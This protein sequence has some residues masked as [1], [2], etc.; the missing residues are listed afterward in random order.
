MLR[1]NKGLLIYLFIIITFNILFLFYPLLNVFGFEFSLANSVLLFFV[2]GIYVINR[3]SK[4]NGISGIVKSDFIKTAIVFIIFLIIPLIITL[5]HSFFTTF[6]SI[7]DGFLFYTVITFPSVILGA[8]TGMLTFSLFNKMRIFLFIIITIL[9][10][11][12]ALFEFYFNPQV[13]F[14]NPVFGFFPGTIYDEGI[15]VTTKLVFYRL[16]NLA[17]FGSIIYFVFKTAGKHFSKLLLGFDSML[18]ASVFIYFSPLLGFSTTNRSLQQDLGKDYKT[19]HFDI[20]FS[21]DI[22]DTLAKKI[23]LEHEYDYVSLA[24]FF[25]ETPQG[26]ITSYVFSSNEQKGKLFGSKNADVAKPWLQQIYISSDSYDQ[27][28]KHELAHVFTREFGTGIFKVADGLNPALIEGAAVAGAPFFGDNTIHYMAKLAY[29]NGYKVKIEHLFSGLNFFGSVSSLSYIYA[30]SFS[31]FL[32]DTYGVKKFE[33]LY[34]DLDFKRIYNKSSDEISKEYY[35]FIDSFNIK[36]NPDKAK[37]YFGRQTIFQKICP[38]FIADR[39]QTAYGYY[40][41]KDYPEAENIFRE[42]LGKT[43][44]YSALMGLSSTLVELGNDLEA[45]AII[46]NKIN[47]FSN[48]AYYYNLQ[49]RLADIEVLNSEFQSASSIYKTIVDENPNRVLFNLANLR[50]EL[51]KDTLKI[52]NYVAGDAVKQVE[53]LSSLNAQSYVYSSLPALID[54]SIITHKSYGD[55]MTE[56]Q[57]ELNVKDYESSYA[58]YCLSKYMA[59]NLDFDK[60]REMA[61][62]S[63]A[64]KSDDNFNEVLNSN[65]QKCEWFYY[66][67]ARILKNTIIKRVE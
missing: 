67:S 44:N 35:K 38:R 8:A 40:T 51:S 55:F 5:L 59:D 9:I 65:L 46:K 62:L 53:I 63:M 39:L 4:R 24:K 3:L 42:I 37:Y 61:V 1:N 19:T 43:N 50:L 22:P 49:F 28:L 23:A 45:A 11:S 57:S 64:F 10:I 2:S 31:K 20:Y 21:H 47:Q 41:N 52:K 33:Q 56:F 17:Y 29:Q 15:K 32:I 6:C 34:S 54:L 13:Y 14:F 12:I 66:N 18:I 16:L 48:T 26:K 58:V 7:R 36:N 30:G 60:A 27:T 25:E